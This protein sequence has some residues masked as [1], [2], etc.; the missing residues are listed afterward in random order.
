VEEF[1]DALEAMNIE[2]FAN[3]WHQDGVVIL[4]FSPKGFPARIV[5]IKKSVINTAVF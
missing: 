2:R 3:I 5:G 4:P 1:V